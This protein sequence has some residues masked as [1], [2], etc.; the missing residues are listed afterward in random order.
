MTQTEQSRHRTRRRLAL[1]TGLALVA[2]GAAASPA[3]ANGNGGIDSGSTTDVGGNA[4][5]PII[6]CSWALNDVDH[7][8]K[9]TPK[10]TYGL[11]DDPVADAGFPCVDD[12]AGAATMPS[13]YTSS[14]MIVV[15]P[16]ADDDPSEAYV[17]LWGAVS[18]SNANPI[19]YFDVYHPD[20]TLKAQIDATQYAN[21]SNPSACDG[22]TGMFQAALDNKE[23]TSAA[24]ANIKDECR[25]QQKGLYYGAFGI[26]KHQPYGT[27]TVN[28]TAATAGGAA[29]T[30]SMLITVL[31]FY[32]LE[33]DFTTVNFGT[34]GPNSHYWQPTAGDFDWDGT[35]NA[36]N[37]KTSVRNTGNAGIGL[38][39]RFASMCLTT[40]PSCTDDKRIDHFDAKFGKVIAGMQSMG[41]TGLAFALESNLASTAKPAPYGNW[42]SFDNDINRTLC[43][44]DVAKIEFSI[45]TENIQAGTYSAIPSGI[46]LRARPNAE[47]PTDDGS[48]YLAN[49]YTGNTPTSNEHWSVP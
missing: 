49:G 48:V 30:H 47:C 32:Q 22:P 33:K 20:G 41:N 42:Y 44:N 16:N 34:V 38:D 12:G 35:N 27:Y 23:L 19:V 25:Y 46:G 36:T 45:Y 1:L 14:S 6:E 28:I 5:A 2:G 17:E 3:S 21:S 18:S 37:Q 8:W 4:Q 39:V 10:M 40:A 11:D 26:S 24:I 7:N 9:S 31:P 13:N 15:K 29:T 43:P